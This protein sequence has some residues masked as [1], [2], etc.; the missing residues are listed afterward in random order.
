MG[1][2]HMLE[3]DVR[4]PKQTRRVGQKPKF[5]EARIEEVKTNPLVPLNDKQRH[6]IRMVNDMDM[7]I[8]TGFAGTSKA[9]PLHSLVLCEDGWK[10]MGEIKV[11]MKVVTP[12]NDLSTVL[13]VHP[14]KNKTVYKVSFKS[15]RVAEC[16]GDHLW[17]V[18]VCN[19]NIRGKAAGVQTLPLS[20]IIEILPDNNVSIPMCGSVGTY[21][22]RDFFI[23][24]YLMGVLLAEGCLKPNVGFSTADKEIVDAFSVWANNNG[25]SIVRLNNKYDYAIR[26]KGAGHKNPAV[27]EIKRLGLWGKRSLDKSVP[28]E[29]M[30]A[31]V[32]Q[33]LQLLK[34]LMD[35]DGSSST[36]RR[37][38]SSGIGYA[39]ASK[40]LSEQVRELV[41]SLGGYAKLSEHST[42]YT[43]KGEKL[44]GRTSYRLYINHPKPKSLFNLERKQNGCSDEYQGGKY[45]LMDKIVSV[46]TVGEMDVQCILIDSEEHL[47]LTDDY[48]VTHNTYI[49][50]VMAC[51]WFRTGMIKKI[52]FTRP[53]ISN[54]KSLGMFKG[55]LI[56]KMSQWLMP[57]INILRERIGEGALEIALK[58][59]DIE[60]VP[61]E[62]LKGYSA[63]DCVFICDEA[64][65]LT[66]DEAKKIVTRQGKNCKMILAGDVSQSE[67]KDK[68]GMKHLL[69]MV[70]K[71]P[72]LN[73]GVIDFNNINDIVR[74]AQCRNWIVA[75]SKEE[76][77]QNK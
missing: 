76:A 9:Q 3:D 27:E 11:G 74:S 64:E 48:I 68:S 69:Y 51:D 65:D 24:P 5:A 1:K 2:V 41:L 52:V 19:Q 70:D 42:S 7:V 16:C 12:N 73:V 25:M 36:T 49:P 38:N 77:E 22:D 31:S 57:V 8:A 15:G 32:A 72:N 28:V 45:E 59:G 34:G 23:P 47:Y 61:L 37:K 50:T 66:I 71:Y 40:K 56:E 44:V 58:R 21:V 54:S 63:Q 26:G 39:S 17:N 30:E 46:E 75:F 4:A 29:Y 62:V 60:F 13:E 55:D 18:R 33:R 10:P 53:N 67:L 6:Y 35:G 14:F 43:Y 20:K